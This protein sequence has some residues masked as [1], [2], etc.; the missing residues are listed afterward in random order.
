MNQKPSSPLV[1]SQRWKLWLSALGLLV[2][3]IAMVAPSWIA[4][5]L[6]I[7]A[8]YII[9]G[10]SLTGIAVLLGTCAAVRC[11]ACGLPLVGHALSHQAHDVWLAWLIS[12][13]VCP[14]CG[15]KS[16]EKHDA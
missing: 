4:A 10:T 2:A 5:L 15:F 11:P 13:Q 7:E 9:L 1:A 3:G 16:P 8:M 6:G 12:V 14:R